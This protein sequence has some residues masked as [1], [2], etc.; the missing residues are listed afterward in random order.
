MHENMHIVRFKGGLGNQLFEYALYK[1]FEEKYGYVRADIFDYKSGV[2]KRNFQLPFLGINVKEA[3][4]QE[5]RELY[6]NPNNKIIKAMI[7][8]FGK[9]T[10]YRERDVYYDEEIINKKKGYFDGYWQSYKYFEKYVGS[11]KKDIFFRNVDK[12]SFLDDIEHDENTVSVHIRLGDYLQNQE[13]YGGICTLEYYKC[14]MNYIVRH[15]EQNGGAKPIFYIFSNDTAGAKKILGE[16]GCIFVDAHSEEEGYKDLF[17]MSR[18]RH[19][20][21]ANSSFSWW[22]AYIN[23]QKESLVIAPSLWMKNVDSKDIVPKH[24][25]TI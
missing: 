23:E 24:W 5:V 4:L 25:I 22:G 13:K 2:E 12:I 3:S 21:I 1:S 15:I 18:C 19:H 11:L 20:I 10:Y 7:K 6:C 14:A 9:E 17:L 8:R 16:E